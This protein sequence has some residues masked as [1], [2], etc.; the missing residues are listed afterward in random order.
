M[1]V[2]AFK[3]HSVRAPLI[4]PPT[5]SKGEYYRQIGGVWRRAAQELG[6][7]ENIIVIGYSLPASDSFFPLLFGLGTVGNKPLR[8]FWVF[9]PDEKV[10]DRFR[11]MLGPGALQ[12]FEHFVRYRV[13]HAQVPNAE[14]SM[15]FSYAIQELRARFEVA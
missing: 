14:V 9:D 7:A 13:P 2:S 8:R 11:T 1:N 5:W 12:R 3:D 15:I 10:G 6:E 4:V